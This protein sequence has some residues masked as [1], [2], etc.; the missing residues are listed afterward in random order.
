M[1]PRL[2]AALVLSLSLA[3]CGR[4]AAQVRLAGDVWVPVRVLGVD[5]LEQPREAANQLRYAMALVPAALFGVADRNTLKQLAAEQTR[6]PLVTEDLT[7]WA[8]A[9]A[10]PWRAGAD[11]KLQI[12]PVDV[13]VARIMTAA[14]SPEGASRAGVGFHDLAQDTNLIL[15]Y[16]DRASSVVGERTLGEPGAVQA[17]P[18]APDA[19]VRLDLHFPAAG[20]Y[21]VRT[22][23]A[24]PI[25]VVA[26]AS[27]TLEVR[28]RE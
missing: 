19:G 15:V 5:G 20:I 13:R 25:V 1:R 10:Q 21:W 2:M 28:T 16:V 17:A 3:A 18:S 7:K 22:A 23:P 14:F 8:A 24:Q 27:P 12:T 9:G 26:P 6:I 11:E 4:G